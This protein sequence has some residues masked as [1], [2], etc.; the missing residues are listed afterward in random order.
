MQMVLTLLIVVCCCLCTSAICSSQ[1]PHLELLHLQGSQYF[2][3]L[4]LW[5]PGP[6]LLQSAGRLRLLQLLLRRCLLQN[7]LP[8]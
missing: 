7:G 5:L 8:A 6:L 1:C 3:R 2:F 4:W